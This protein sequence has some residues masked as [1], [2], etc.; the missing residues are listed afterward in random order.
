MD[1]FIYSNTIFLLTA[2][3][4]LTVGNIAQKTKTKN[5]T[6]NWNIPR[7]KRGGRWSALC[8]HRIHEKKSLIHQIPG[9]LPKNKNKNKNS[10]AYLR[11][12]WP[13]TNMLSLNNIHGHENEKTDGTTQAN[14]GEWNAARTRSL[15]QAYVIQLPCQQRRTYKGDKLA[16]RNWWSCN[17]QVQKNKKNKNPTI[18]A[19]WFAQSL[20]NK[21]KRNRSLKK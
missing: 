6:V 10:W 17:V 12:T 5:F 13:S 8:C 19:V 14:T 1:L 7:D 20:C 16:Q 18:K 2:C 15:K 9:N 11:I 4:N 3:L 21:V